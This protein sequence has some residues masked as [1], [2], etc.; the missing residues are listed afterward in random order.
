METTALRAVAVAVRSTSGR[1][2]PACPPN[3]PISGAGPA[4]VKPSASAPS[5][6]SCEAVGLTGAGSRSYAV[7]EPRAVRVTPSTLPGPGP[8]ARAPARTRAKRAPAA[9]AGAAEGRAL[10]EVKKVLTSP[11]VDAARG[12]MTTEP[13]A[14]LRH[15]G[16]L[17]SW[18]GDTARRESLP[19]SGVTARVQ[20]RCVRCKR[21]RSPTPPMEGVCGG[22]F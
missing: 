9:G 16:P 12:P 10:G 1:Q 13:I 21:S 2:A 3:R 7:P 8:G 18:P 15:S 14:R 17:Q 5:A 11:P 20:D 4:A 19:T 6:A 22:V